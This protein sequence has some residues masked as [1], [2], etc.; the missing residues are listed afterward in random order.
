MAE[1]GAQVKARRMIFVEVDG[2]ELLFRP[3]GR[4]EAQ[5]AAQAISENPSDAEETAHAVCR[6][7][8]LDK[9]AFDAIC[10][11]YPRLM[12][13]S[14]GVYIELQ[15]DARRRKIEDE[16][17]A[18]AQFKRS[19]RDL[20]QKAL[21][22]LAFKAYSGG[23]WCVDTLA[24]ALTLADWASKTNGIFVMFQALMKALSRKKR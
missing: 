2:S 23:D 3:L 21:G 8:C 20:K 11:V 9:E 12:T 15:K 4:L 24:G 6:E 5:A 17:A 14:G 13:G 22:L 1:P 18:G 19:E 16:K 10:D 7:C